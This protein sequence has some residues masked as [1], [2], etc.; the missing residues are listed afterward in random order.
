MFFTKNNSNYMEKKHSRANVPVIIVIVIIVLA[1]TGM[2][3]RC[4]DGK[5]DVAKE[6]VKPRGDT[7]AV[8]IEMSPLT[9]NLR[10]DT[11]DGFD[12][13]V[14]RNIAAVHGL[15]VKFYPVAD[16]E[17]AFQGLYDHK[18]NILV[19]SLPSTSAMKQYF[20]LTDAVYYDRQVLVQRA[21]SAGGRGPVL[22]QEQLLGDTVWVAEGSPYKTRL[23][24]MSLELGDT[25]F[26]ECVPGYS[27]EQLAILTAL[28]EVRQAVVN[29]AIAGRIAAH[30]PQLDVSTPISLSQFQV[31]A[32]APHDT[33]LLDSLNSWLAEFK[34]TDAYRT[35]AEKYDVE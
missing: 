34:G 32:V 35:L 4:A 28:G 24:N 2:A 25:I 9:Y 16:L 6:Y 1:V 21:D 3:R 26:V 17:A 29:K 33:V 14:L 11:A 5:S 19:G 13:Q 20:P 7:L 18:Y 30:Y 27:S 31:W 22:S 8:A 10:N 15:Q 23:R 12:Y